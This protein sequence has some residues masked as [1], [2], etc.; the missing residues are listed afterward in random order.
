MSKINSQSPST[1]GQPNAFPLA[2]V[3]NDVLGRIIAKCDAQSLLNLSCASKTMKAACSQDEKL[4]II[5]SINAGER[6]VDTA[7]PNRM[8]PLASAINLAD[9]GY[10]E[11]L[12]GR[13]AS[14]ELC[15]NMNDLPNGLTVK[16]LLE[17]SDCQKLKRLPDDFKVMGHF[18]VYNC[19]SLTGESSG[20]TVAG[21]LL[22]W[23]CDKLATLPKGTS[24]QRTSE[25]G[26]V[27]LRDCSSLTELKDLVAA[28]NL[29][30]RDCNGLTRSH[31]PVYSNVKGKIFFN[32][33]H[34]NP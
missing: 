33:E 28:G 12:L 32:G 26:T 20:L 1:G 10:I 3:G 22:F 19:R 34:L 13:G 24:T 9:K 27:T 18:K 7:L 17:I 2:Q 31:L 23:G 16:G 29:D 14:L 11:M 21:N 4:Q 15:K 25:L 6:K 5:Q 30:I 8:T